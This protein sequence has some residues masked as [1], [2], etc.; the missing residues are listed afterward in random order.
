MALFTVTFVDSSGFA[1]AQK[2][3]CHHRTPAM[4]RNIFHHLSDRLPGS[5]P[6]D[7]IRYLQAPVQLWLG[8]DVH[9]YEN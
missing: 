6:A 1:S 7:P 3:R 4:Q 2:I 5:V 9:D 8:R